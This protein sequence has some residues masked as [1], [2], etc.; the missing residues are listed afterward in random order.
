VV[1]VTQIKKIIVTGDRDV[2]L[3]TLLNQLYTM[4]NISTKPKWEQLEVALQ[5]LKIFL[6]LAAYMRLPEIEEELQTMCKA[7]IIPELSEDSST[8]LITD[9]DLAFFKL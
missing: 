2:L 9:F 6:P 3:I 5:S 4:Q 7:I 8:S 1:E